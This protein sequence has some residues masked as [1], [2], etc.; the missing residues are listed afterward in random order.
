GGGRAAGARR[1]GG[2]S[3]DGQ[4]DRQGR[5]R[6]RGPERRR[7]RS[8]PGRQDRDLGGRRDRACV[9]ENVGEAD[10]RRDRRDRQ[11]QGRRRSHGAGP[12]GHVRDRRPRGGVGPGQQA[13]ARGGRGG[14]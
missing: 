14:A 13:P 7:N 4:E 10:E 12:L 1:A 6:V 9:R 8:S 2:E 5:H 3:G 11:D